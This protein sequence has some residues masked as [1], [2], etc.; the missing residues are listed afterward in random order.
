[1][2]KYNVGDTVTLITES[3]TLYI[4]TSRHGYKK[5][6]NGETT[7]VFDYELIQIL[8]VKQG[9]AS[10]YSF[11]MKAEDVLVLYA[12]YQTKMWHMMVDFIRRD[13]K[14]NNC[15]E[16]PEF[17]TLVVATLEGKV[18]TK[19]G[20]IAYNDESIRYVYDTI[21][22][23][24]EALSDL[25][26]LIEMFGDDTEDSPTVQQYIKEKKKVIKQL[27]KLTS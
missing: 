24:L 26:L 21:D 25:S 23:C 12:R 4:V 22:D 2:A 9:P 8:P 19:Q 20:R 7:D 3:D 13:R 11:N 14:K 16:E 5:V 27:K 17:L 15:F 10:G 1:M 6:K 18:G